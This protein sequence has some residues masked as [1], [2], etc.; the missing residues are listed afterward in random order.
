MFHFLE[1]VRV[2]LVLF[3]GHSKVEISSHGFYLYHII[4]YGDEIMN[5]TTFLSGHFYVTIY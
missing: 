3:R 4:K 5:K 2:H 1:I